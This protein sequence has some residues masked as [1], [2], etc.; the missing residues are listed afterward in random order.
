MRGK[1]LAPAHAGHGPGFHQCLPD[2]MLRMSVLA[3]PIFF[4]WRV[5]SAAF[6]IAVFGWGVSFYGPPVFLEAI[7]KRR[8]WPVSLV[9]ATVTCHFLF[10]ALIVANLTA[11][12]R[13]FGLLAVTRGGALVAASGMVGWAVAEEPWQLFAATLLS[14]FG[15]AATGAAAINAMV[16]PWFARRRPAALSSAYNGASVGG[17]L[18]SPL[19]AALIAALGFPGAAVLIGGIMVLVIWCLS[20]RYLGRTPASMG[21]CRTATY[22]MQALRSGTRML[23]RPC[24]GSRSG[25]V[26]ASSLLLP[27][28]LL[29]FSRRSA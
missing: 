25:S 13:R 2:R 9:S 10:G 8:G 20:G 24:Q 22:R 12:Y 23:L 21:C 19:W 29:A 14:G 3:A 18:L 1:C 6:I 16:S 11:L 28:P 4:G 27:Q 7:H 17:V 15:W 5:V 26:G